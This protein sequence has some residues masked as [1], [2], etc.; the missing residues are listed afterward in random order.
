MRSR[1]LL[2]FCFCALSA[3]G[4]SRA[5]DA[6][7][8]APSSSSAPPPAATCTATAAADVAVASDD[9]NGFPPYAVDACTLVYVSTAGTLVARDLATGSEVT[10]AGVDETPRRPTI[11]GAVVAW[12]ATAGAS[13]V[14]RVR[15]N[16]V[17][18]TLAGAFAN[19]GEPRA[20]GGVVVFTASVGD[21]ASGDT[22]VWLF[23]P[24]TT[25]VTRVIAGTA[26]QRFADVSA[27]YVA[28]TDFSEDPD[29]RYSGDGTDLADI[30]VLDRAT[31]A[32]THR[33]A[34]GKQAFPMLADGGLIAYLDWSAIHPEPKLVL[35]QLKVGA[36][37]AP[38]AS[39]RLVADVRYLSSEY[40]RPAVSGATIE[41]VANPDGNTVLWRAPADGSVAPAAVAGLDGLV[42]YAPAPTAAFTVL[43][44]A[45][46]PDFSPRLRAVGRGP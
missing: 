40:A 29:G 24:K 20:G 32:V 11:S 16:G 26:Q 34:P 13:S 31:G 10:I 9:L 33:A 15:V 1:T 43:A 17:T 39:D 37:A 2:L 7:S 28:A 14:V 4:G 44:A 41:W 38:P 46:S 6:A 27:S 19:A 12:Q 23:D 18:S 25:A 3:C 45:S 8:P 21:L 5:D 22:D 35:Y 42:L 30:V 36:I